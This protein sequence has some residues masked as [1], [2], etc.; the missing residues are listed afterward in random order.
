[1]RKLVELFFGFI[2]LM[3]TCTAFAETV[4]FDVSC[5]IPS[6][7]GVNAPAI[8]ENTIVNAAS[9][10]DTTV[11]S[12]NTKVSSSDVQDSSDSDPEQ[13]PE[14]MIASNKKDGKK[15]LL[16]AEKKESGTMLRTIYAP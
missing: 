11:S 8:V 5:T 3:I 6:I 1:M 15:N 14:S 2:S 13:E 12:S 10:T 16:L 9:A 4:T 7:P